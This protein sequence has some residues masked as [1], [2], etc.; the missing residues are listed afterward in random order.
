MMNGCGRSVVT[1]VAMLLFICTRTI[2]AADPLPTGPLPP[3][4]PTSVVVQQAREAIANLAKPNYQAREAATKTLLALGEPILPELR[5]AYRETENPEVERRVEVL[6]ETI[7]R[8]RLTE[9]R[10]I[11][12]TGKNIPVAELLKQIGKQ[13]GYRLSY[14]ES[15]TLKGCKLNVAWTKKPFWEAIDEVANASGLTISYGGEAENPEISLSEN[16][17][18]DPHVS[19]SGPFRIVA[20]NINSN[21]N[22][23]LSNIPRRFAQSQQYESLNVNF[24]LMSEPKNP[25]ISVQPLV[26]TKATDD[27]NNSLLSANEEHNSY[28]SSPYQYRSFNQYLSL[29][30]S[31][32][33]RRANMIKELKFQTKLSLQSDSRPE[34][35]IEN[36]LTA[37]SPKGVSKA[38]EITVDSVSEAA[39]MLTLK[40]TARQLRPDP[41]DY[42]WQNSLTQRIEIHDAAGVPYEL[43]SVDENSN[44]GNGE[45]K[46]SISYRPPSKTKAGKPAKLVL[47]EW[48]T[49]SQ[50]VSFQFRDLP[51]P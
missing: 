24:M 48:I 46:T 45:L 16:D 47:I 29:N 26:V 10:R 14:S 3:G 5:N 11:T 20:T 36:L 33:D 35:T 12:L 17:S 9:P 4:A 49:I 25:M 42:S 7:N 39:G 34:L 19:Y 15:D 51:L 31:R 43:V 37:K 23:N 30:L 6:L 21:R 32:S 38:T 1:V 40:L 27:L 50:E 22:V 44:Q 18:F 8:K 13:S 28:Y 41:N 2:V